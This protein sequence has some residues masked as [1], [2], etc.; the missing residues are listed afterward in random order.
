[1]VRARTTFVIGGMTR[2]AYRRER[3]RNQK[4]LECIAQIIWRVSVVDNLKKIPMSI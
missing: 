1:M 4:I 2:Y 3:K